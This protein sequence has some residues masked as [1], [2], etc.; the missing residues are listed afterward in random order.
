[1]IVLH[2]Q[3]EQ[4]Q[5]QIGRALAQVCAGNGLIFLKGDLGAGKTTFARGFLRGMGHTG[6]VKSPTYT[7]IEPYEINGNHCYHLDLYRLADPDELEFLGIRDLLEGNAVLL[8][9]WPEQG[10]D[11]LPAPDLLVTIL[12]QD[13]GRELSIEAKSTRGVRLLDELRIQLAA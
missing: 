9:E 3:T 2:P 10:G 4:A 8:V 5:E 1:V 13:E 11:A 12:Y 6:S 7:L